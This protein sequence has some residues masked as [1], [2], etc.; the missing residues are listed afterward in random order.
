MKHARKLASL[1]LALVMVFALATTAFAA[2]TKYTITITNAP[3]GHTYEAYQIF[4]GDLA[5]K[6][7][8]KVLSNI[9]WGSG[10]TEAG[11]NA[12]GIAAKKAESLKTEENA[13]AFAEEVAQY[14]QNPPAVSTEGTPGSY[15]ITGLSAGYYLVK[16]ND[17]PL[18]NPDD[19]YTA[20]IMQV[21][22]N[23]TAEPKGDKPT[24]NKQIKHNDNNSWGVVGDNQIGDTVDFR[25]ISTV[26]DTAGYTTY[27]YTIS[28][29]MSA[30]LTSNV[31]NAADVTIKVN[32]DDNKKLA[33]DYY[34][35]RADGNSFT[36]DVHILEAVNAGVLTKGDSLYAY[37]TGVLNAN[38]K[39]YDEKQDNTAHL[40]YS[41][42]PNNGEDKG[43]TP[44]KTVYDWTFK[45][46][47]NKVDKDSNAL[48]GAKFVLSK[49]ATIKVADLKCGD[50]GV[51]TVTEKLIGLVK[52]GDNEY[53]IALPGETGTVYYIEAGNPVI[54]G[55]DDNVKYYLYE[56][57][58][59]EGYNLLSDPVS[60]EIAAQYNA[61]GSVCTPA[62]TINQGAPSKTLSTDVVNQAGTVLPS[63]GGMGTTVFYVLGA[64]LVLGAGVLLVTKK[65]MS[66]NEG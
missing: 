14:L 19:F 40:E 39:V 38:A 4:A 54:K 47:I 5:D 46:G 12:L 26:P 43:K 31:K 29:T 24:L 18:S 66:R 48:N 50:D 60:F 2:D 16:D 6:D 15:T 34:T 59:P 51:P 9:V 64:V 22:G 44:D 28:D 62:V 13:K 7:G 61:D 3:T 49:S 10:V 65:R 37:Y 17:N 32:D 27:T 57:K 56:T 36:I 25:T 52:T 21:V 23:V 8:K 45:M 30:G 35:V 11:K 63:T 53:R 58:S 55:L 33:A 1:L 41:N 42:N 20:Y